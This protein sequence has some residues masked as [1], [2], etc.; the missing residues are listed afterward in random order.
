L[1]SG[2]AH[3]AHPI[4]KFN[5][6]L[7]L[8]LL[9]SVVSHFKFLSKSIS[10]NRF[11]TFL[12]THDCLNEMFIFSGKPVVVTALLA[13]YITASKEYLKLE[14]KLFRCLE[15]TFLKFSFKSVNS[16]KSY[17]RKQ[18]GLFLFFETQCRTVHAQR[19]SPRDVEFGPIRTKVEPVG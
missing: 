8:I 10:S 3:T 13:I 4:A 1:G 6:D 14:D 12:L 7:A 18:N 16:S 9:F 5:R 19:I 17:A 11:T 15:S 2:R